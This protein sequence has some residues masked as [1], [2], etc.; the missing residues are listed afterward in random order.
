MR[1]APARWRRPAQGGL[2]LALSALFIAA[3]EALRLPAAFL[4]GPMAAAAV[5]AGSGAAL[6]VPALLFVAAQA[7]I[8][9]M[10]AGS[11]PPSLGLEILHHWPVFALGTVSV[12]LA[13]AG[14]GF[15]LMRWQV[16]PGSTAVWGAMPGAASAM[17]LMAEAYGADMRLVAFMQYLRVVC[18]ASVASVV[19]RVWLPAGHAAHHAAAAPWLA[20]VPVLPFAGTLGLA[21]GGAWLGRVLRVPAGAFLVPMFAGIALS[22]TGLMAIVLPRPLLAA[23]YVLLGWSIGMRFNAPI[24]RYAARALPRILLS[25]AS[26]VAL[27]GLFAVLLHRFA[28]VE[29]LTAYLATSPGGA[30]SVAIIAAGSGVDMPFVMAMQIGRFMLVLVAG[31]A[32]ARAVA[33]LQPA[34]RPPGDGS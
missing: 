18:V 25:I 34:P 4:V 7:A 24:L 29:P 9:C 12:L 6:P 11:L 31:P 27:C 5:L 14:L 3:L 23:A 32:L 17:T 2:L 10:I 16:L 22:T 20:P 19:A 21:A 30:D 8:G 13:A 15:L 1:L 33:A 28:G 26:L